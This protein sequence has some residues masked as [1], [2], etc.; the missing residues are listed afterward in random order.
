MMPYRKLPADLY[1]EETRNRWVW[2][3]SRRSKNRSPGGCLGDRLI[4]RL[5]CQAPIITLSL[6]VASQD[7]PVSI[8]ISILSYQ[9]LTVVVLNII[10]IF[11]PHSTL[12]YDDDMQHCTHWTIVFP[13][14]DCNITKKSNSSKGHVSAFC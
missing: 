3:R 4:D 6:Q 7:L 11:R 12:Y 9:H 2:L 10:L 8:L 5:K 1:L 14:A 13:P